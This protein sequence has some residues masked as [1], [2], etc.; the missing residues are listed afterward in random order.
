MA[1]RKYFVFSFTRSA[2]SVEASS[3]SKTFSEAATMGG[4]MELE[5]R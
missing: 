2:S 1:S 4:A 3:I 5:K